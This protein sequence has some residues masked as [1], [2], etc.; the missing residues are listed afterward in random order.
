M[1]D[2]ILALSKKLISIPSTRE[3]V[4]S[5]DRVLDLVVS[6]LKS[7]KFQSFEKNG[8]PSVLYF[9]QSVNPKKFKVILNAHLDVVLGNRDQFIPLVRGDRL[10]GRGAYDMKAAA[11]AEI[12]LFK[13]L[14]GKLSFPFGLQLVTD[15]EIGGFNGTLYQYQQGIRTECMLVG[16][17]SSNFDIGIHSK[18]VIWMNIAFKGVS[19]HAAYPW[20][21]KNAIWVM[22]SFLNKLGKKYPVPDVETWKTTV[23]VAVA[24]TANTTNNKVPDDV[25]LKLDIRYIPEDK[26]KVIKNITSFLP[27]DATVE[28]FENAPARTTDKHS[29]YVSQ[30]RSIAENILKKPVSIVGKPHATDLRHFPEAVGLEFGPVG[31]GPHRDDE[32]V[33]IKGLMTYFSILREFLLSVN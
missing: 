1:V 29:A 17:T 5:F 7:F 14:A 22:N 15:E 9:N 16:E 30:L 13:D 21:G 3:D 23:N 11:A 10:Y 2:S 6:E 27:A 26:D 20:D 28:I 18:G 19:S 31:Y 12:L 32:W 4:K 33:S 24:S 25:Q 8:N